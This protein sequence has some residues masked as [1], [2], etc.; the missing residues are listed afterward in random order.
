MIL[1]FKYFVKIDSDITFYNIIRVETMINNSTGK[2]DWWENKGELDLVIIT[3]T[4]LILGAIILTTI[5]G[6]HLS[7]PAAHGQTNI[8]V[9]ET[10]S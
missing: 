8:I 5:I 2:L 4:S 1:L 9:K 7:P 10:C 6:E 3:L